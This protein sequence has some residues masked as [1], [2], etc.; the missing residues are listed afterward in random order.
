[1]R[2]ETRAGKL[3]S[4]GAL[5]ATATRPA[6]DE[7]LDGMPDQELAYLAI[8]ATRRVKRR[9]TRGQGR[10]LRSKGF[11]RGRSSPLDDALRRIG[12]ELMEFE[13]PGETW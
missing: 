4:L 10:E 7:L 8:E 3:V 12:G 13:D 5:S 6:I 1:M 11:G 2:E 9:L